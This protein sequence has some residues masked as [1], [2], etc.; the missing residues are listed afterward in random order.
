MYFR[1]IIQDFTGNGF[2]YQFS[3][4]YDNFQVLRQAETVQVRRQGKE[5]IT[6]HAP[7]DVFK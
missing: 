3:Q 1:R 7:I 5:I 4:F 2:S 6:A